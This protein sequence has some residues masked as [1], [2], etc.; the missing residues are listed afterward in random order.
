[1]NLAYIYERREITVSIQVSFF[2]KVDNYSSVLIHR[3]HINRVIKKENLFAQ[4]IHHE[5]VRDN[6]NG[7]TVFNTVLNVTIVFESLPVI[8]DV[9]QSVCNIV[10]AE[11]LKP[12]NYALIT[13]N[14]GTKKEQS[15][16]LRIK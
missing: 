2:V 13:L 15:H 14:P 4:I 5:S 12:G 7:N 3:I 16:F 8:S 11:G 10:T 9:Y 1:M 6:Q